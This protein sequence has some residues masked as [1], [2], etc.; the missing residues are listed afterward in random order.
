MHQITI[1]ARGVR[2]EY[3]L[4]KVKRAGFSKWSVALRKDKIKG[5]KRKEKP[6]THIC[7]NFRI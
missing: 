3:N 5:T 4:G 2:M 7:D 6:D 1:Q